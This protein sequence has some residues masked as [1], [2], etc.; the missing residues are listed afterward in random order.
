[1]R[2]SPSLLITASLAAVLAAGCTTTAT[3]PET[4]ASVSRALTADRSPDQWRALAERAGKRYEA[5]PGNA[6]VAL[7]YGSALRATGQSAQAVAVLEKAAIL[8]SSDKDILGAFGRALADAGRLNQ[9]LEVLSK[10]HRPEQPDWTILNAQGAILDQM[11]R[12]QEARNYYQTALKIT[13]NE[14]AILSN[15]GL[16]Y[17]LEKDLKQAETVLKLAASQPRATARV[18]QNLA[19]VYVLQGRQAEAVAALTGDLGPEGAKQAVADLSNKQR[20]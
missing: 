13:P 1:M 9:A 5:D 10:A 19:L 16:S 2:P 4:T 11:G 17:V 20:G 7:A 8:H 15:L 14:P 6:G 12:G 18:R 3:A